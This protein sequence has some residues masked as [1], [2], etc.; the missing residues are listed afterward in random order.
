MLRRDPAGVYDEMTFATRDR[1]RHVVEHLARRTRTVEH[2]V[3]SGAVALALEALNSG[4]P[5]DALHAAHVGYY[6]VDEGRA[7]LEKS[8]EY[9]SGVRE[10]MYRWAKRHPTVTYIGAVTK[11]IK[12]A[13]GVLI[14]GVNRH[15]KR[16]DG[17]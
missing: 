12:L 2:E 14:L 11:R 10:S 8:L 13:T 7:A 5:A 16:F 9:R 4:A 15:C 1:Y 17:R 6:L 3:A